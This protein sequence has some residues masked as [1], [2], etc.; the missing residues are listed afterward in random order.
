M[1]DGTTHLA[2]K[3]EH[4]VDLGEGGRG[5]ILAV[6]L[7]DAAAGD[8]ATLVDTV[9][10]ATENLAAVADDERV[11]DKVAGEYVSEAVLDKGYHSEQ[12]LLDLE[13]M[14]GDFPFPPAAHLMPPRV[15]A[16][17]AGR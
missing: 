3:A 11:A 12:G 10:A 1:K 9:V 16:G 13:E 8:T 15:A 2:H 4:A 14:A 7:C 5:A 17:A 6:N